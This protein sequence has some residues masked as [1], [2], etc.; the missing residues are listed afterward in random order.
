M[1]GNGSAVAEIVDSNAK[2]TQ[3]VYTDATKGQI[4]F[5]N[6]LGPRNPVGQGTVDVG[7][8][9]TSGTRTSTTAFSRSRLREPCS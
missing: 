6:V 9:R 8:R 5:V 2:G 1:A 7:A 3:L 4:G